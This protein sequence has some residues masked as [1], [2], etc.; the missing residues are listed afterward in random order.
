MKKKFIVTGGAGFIGSNIVARILKDGNT[1]VILDNLSRKGA[2]TNLKWL[3]SLGD[4]T[5]IKCDVT[6]KDAVF[7]AVQAHKDVAMVIH[8]AG[9]VAVT[10]SVADPHGD[11][12]DN[13]HGTVNVLE[14]VRQ[15]NI[16]PLVAYAS[17]NKVY[18]GMEHVKIVKNKNRYR[19]RDYPKGIPETMLLDFHSPYGCSKGTGDQYVRDYYRIYGIPTVVFR[20]SCIYGPRQFGIEDQGWVAWFVIAAMMGKKISIYGDGL[21]VRDILYIDDLVDAYMLAAK[22]V[23]KVAGK[24]FNVGGGPKNTLS[25][26]AEFGPML[27][28][29]TGRKLK[30]ARGPWREGDQPVYISDISLVKKELGWKPKVAPNVG[31]KKLHAWIEEH[32]DIIKKE[33]AEKLSNS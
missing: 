4:V 19:Y 29:L 15:N 28:E 6:K 32:Q 16:K 1:V 22:N 10:T 8:L 11:F 24:V 18:G 25:I 13:A 14:A 23:K 7:R 5:F 26:W 9:Q 27:E 20:Q 2:R 3:Q 21:Q 31:I 30:P 17:T 12:L 33:L